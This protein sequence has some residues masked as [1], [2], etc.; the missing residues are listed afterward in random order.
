MIDNLVSVYL[1]WA[2][3]SI[4]ICCYLKTDIPS[5]NLRLS[6]IKAGKLNAYFVDRIG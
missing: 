3:T 5:L 6:T 1:R 2:L 4:S